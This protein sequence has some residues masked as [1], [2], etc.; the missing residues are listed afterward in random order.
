MGSDPLHVTFEDDD[1]YLFIIAELS[2]IFFVSDIPPS[3]SVFTNDRQKTKNVVKN[4]CVV[5]V[6][7]VVGIEV[8]ADRTL[9]DESVKMTFIAVSIT[10]SE[11]FRMALLEAVLACLKIASPSFSM[12]LAILF[13]LKKKHKI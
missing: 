2:F 12:T 4:K 9:F 11:A 5:V 10:D 1:I 8:V 13:C 6:V 7:V 3:I